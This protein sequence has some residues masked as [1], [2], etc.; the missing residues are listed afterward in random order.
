MSAAP[1]PLY[2]P[3]GGTARGHLAFSVG[4]N[5]LFQTA[6]QNQDRKRVAPLDYDVHRMITNVGR[7]T[8][9]SL[10]RNV[11]SNHRSIAK[12]IEESAELSGSTFLP[13]YYGRNVEWGETAEAW[14]ENHDRVCDIAGPPYNMRT[15]RRLLRT[16]IMHTGDMLTVLIKTKEGFPMLQ[17]IP[18]HRVGSAFETRFVQGGTYDGARLM[19]GVILDDYNRAIAYRVN[20]G[21]NPFDYTQ[22]VDIP[23]RD[24][25]LSFIPLFVGQVRGFS[26]LG[27]IA[28]EAQDVRETDLNQ[29]LQGK[30]A[31]SVGILE[32]NELGEAPPPGDTGI[33]VTTA[34]TGTALATE[35]MGDGISVRY[36]RSS[37]PNAGIEMLK[38]DN[39]SLN[40]QEYRKSVLRDIYAGIGSSVDF[41]LDPTKIGGA[42]LRVLVDRMNRGFKAFQDLVLTPACMRFDGFRV[43]SAI[44]S[45]SLP[46]DPDWW[47]WTYQGPA[48]LTADKK[49][50]SEVDIAEIASGLKTR[51]TG[52]A[53]RGAY[54]DDVDRE[55]EADADRR[56]TMAQNIATKFKIT[57]QDAYNSL[58]NEQPNGLPVP[59]PVKEEAPADA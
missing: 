55:K 7:R 30:L 12:A 43:A 19:D 15:Y 5:S 39:P 16:E 35:T 9:M 34:G 32:R 11:Y 4:S 40:Q 10:G 26:E 54:I 3:R 20:T 46:E 22:F 1:V 50:D 52:I 6:T 51:R 21:E 14:L 42:P 56:W 29:R 58:W 13:Q 48:Q 41:H 53:N 33:P 38:N 8:M 44:Q 31:S 59:A 23:A 47:K 57:I 28:Y 45:G 27:M 18:G 24:C 36:F 17:C 25:F 37:D 2:G 49:Y